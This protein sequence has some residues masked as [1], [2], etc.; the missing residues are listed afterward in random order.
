MLLARLRKGRGPPFGNGE[1]RRKVRYRISN[2]PLP[3]Q[4]CVRQQFKAAQAAQL[5]H[6]SLINGL[7]V[8]FEALRSLP[9][10][11]EAILVACDVMDADG[12][13]VR[14][15]PLEERR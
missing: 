15:E 7:R 12:Q 6:Y 9:R 3:N 2:K 1:N 14:P 11:A 4:R 8:G 13:D 5:K 10:E